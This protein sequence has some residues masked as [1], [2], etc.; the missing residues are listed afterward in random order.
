MS[1][2]DTAV[3]D[4]LASA[5]AATNS[6]SN[7]ILG[8]LSVHWRA[9][10]GLTLLSVLWGYNWVQMKIAVHYAVPVDF[11]AIRTTL[12]AAV[13]FI[14]MALR[15][16][17]LRPHRFR[18]TVL[19]GLLQTTG[20]FGLSMWALNA[21]AA[22]RTAVLVYTMPFWVLLFAWPLLGERPSRWQWIAGLFA[23][24]GL[25]LII[26]PWAEMG[27]RISIVLA[28]LAGLS[29]GLGVIQAKKMRMKNRE[30]L[31]VTA[32]QMA[33]GSLPFILIASLT[34][35]HPIHWTSDFIVALA[36]NIIPGNVIAWLLWMYVVG[37][38]PAGVAGMGLLGAPLVG[39]LSSWIQ[40]GEV[41]QPI[42]RAGMIFI[43]FGL[44]MLTAG[45]LIKNRR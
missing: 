36:Y 9:V 41:P 19:L 4:G 24:T 34:S 5:I 38:L 11:A 17:P 37:K 39:L 30:V 13:M 45:G 33:L 31:Q 29:W 44:C 42:D 14:Y 10:A 1:T 35:A 3:I 27:T 22:G 6:A 25:V 43:V 21:G 12:G 20:F 8:W 18:A 15:G 16:I 23:L 28:I 40:L 7:P 2:K 32:W 26:Q